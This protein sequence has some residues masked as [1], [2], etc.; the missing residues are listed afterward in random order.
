MIVQLG[1]MIMDMDS[2]LHVWQDVLNVMGQE[3]INV[4]DVRKDFI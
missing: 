4:V 1:G 3:K 2:V